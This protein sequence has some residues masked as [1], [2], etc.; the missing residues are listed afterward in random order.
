MAGIYSDIRKAVRRA[1]IQSL[2]EFFP[3]KE[4]QDKYVLLS[5]TGGSEPISSYVSINIL[6]IDQQGRT[7]TS[8][9]AILVDDEYFISVQASYEVTIQISFCGSLAGDMA[10]SFTQRINNNPI[11]MEGSRRESLGVMRK[12]NLRRSPQRRDT[13]WVEYFNQDVVF[14]YLVNTQQ[15][16]D[17]VETVVVEAKAQDPSDTFTVPPNVPIPQ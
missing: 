13:Q 10:H 15:K 7:H 14:S 4:D 16:V 2:L 11:A 3:T 6:G 12:S 9:Q 17:Y 5:H 8:G 1:T